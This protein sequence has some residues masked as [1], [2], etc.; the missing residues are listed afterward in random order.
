MLN[1]AAVQAL[2]LRYLRWA[3]ERGLTQAERTRH[4]FEGRILTRDVVFATGLGGS[5][6]SPPQIIV[7]TALAVEAPVLLTRRREPPPSKTTTL[8]REVLDAT[9]EGVRNLGLTSRFV[10]ITFNPEVEPELFDVAL[11]AVEERLRLL[12]G[13][14]DL[15][16][17][18]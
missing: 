7:S 11:D 8:L 15:P 18:G 2:A 5:T 3:T 14:G 17:R 13:A 16:Y 12:T 9:G 10:R 1:E 6:P 4:R